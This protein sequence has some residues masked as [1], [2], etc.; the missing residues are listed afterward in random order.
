MLRIH[1]DMRKLEMEPLVK[2][3]VHK[4][5]YDILKTLLGSDIL[6]M[7]IQAAL[8]LIFVLTF[9]LFAVWP[10]GMVLGAGD[11]GLWHEASQ[12]QHTRPGTC[13]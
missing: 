6:A 1:G 5:I 11:S 7:V 4:M 13:Q 3:Q 12:L 2:D 9:V 8:P 10:V